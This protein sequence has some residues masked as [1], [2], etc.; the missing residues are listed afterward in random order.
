[1]TELLI[2]K[3][4]TIRQQQNKTGQTA[5]QLA[6]KNGFSRIAYLVEHGVAPPPSLEDDGSKFAG[7][8]Y[9]VEELQYAARTGQMQVIREFCEEQYESREE[10]LQICAALIP[11]AKQFKQNEAF[12]ALQVY[13]KKE[14]TARSTSNFDDDLV[15]LK[16]DH[17]VILKTL[18]TGLGQTIADS[19]QTLDP[20]DPKTYIQFFASITTNVQQRAEE[21]ASVANVRDIDR[22]SKKDLEDV[23]QKLA[24]ITSYMKNLNKEKRNVAKRLKEYE[25]QLLKQR[26]LSA[27]DRKRIFEMKEDCKNQLHTYEC[28]TTLQDRNRESVLNRRNILQFLK[29]EP[30]LILFYRTIEI[31]LQSLFVA[32]LTAQGGYLTTVMQSRHGSS[33]KVLNAVPTATD[34]LPSG[35]YQAELLSSLHSY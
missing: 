15:R 8:K 31:R 19:P 13:Y 30:N 21:L 24:T 16:K 23:D 12:A 22:V 5:L 20:S 25:E 2:N 10:K 7:S 1:M 3:Y 32:V 33:S 11:V 29:T 14:L 35:Q 34:I 17:Q 6:Q 4:P 18:L 26:E 28:S 9:T 27:L